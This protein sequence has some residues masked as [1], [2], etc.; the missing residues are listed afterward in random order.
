LCDLWLPGGMDGYAVASACK[1]Q[2]P[3]QN[4]RLVA[5]SGYSSPAT[6]ADAMAAGFDSFLVKPLT[7][8]SL[9]ALV[10]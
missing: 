5:A 7:E 4:V 3:L 2:V 8:E 6:L 9:Q 10:R 1:A